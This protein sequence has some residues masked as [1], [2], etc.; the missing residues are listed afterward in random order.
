LPVKQGGSYID[1]QREE[2]LGLR[3]EVIRI[4]AKY[5]PQ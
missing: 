3:Q 5:R 1:V 2:Y 4:A